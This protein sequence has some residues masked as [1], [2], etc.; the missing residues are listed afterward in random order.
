MKRKSFCLLILFII[1][2]TAFFCS[3]SGGNAE[4]SVEKSAS[5]SAKETPFD[6]I[7]ELTGPAKENIS[8]FLNGDIT[9]IKITDYCVDSGDPPEYVLSDGAKIKEFANLLSHESWSAEDDDVYT[10]EKF[11][12]TKFELKNKQDTVAVINL[13]TWMVDAY[14]VAEISGGSRTASFRISERAYFDLRAL[15]TGKYYLHKSDLKKPDKEISLKLQNKMLYGL[16]EDEKSVVCGDLRQAHYCLESLLLEN[17]SFL[18][19]PNGAGWDLAVTGFS[20]NVIR[21]NFSFGGVLKLLESICSNLKDRD[22][23]KAF[24]KMHNDLQSACDKRDLKGV[25]KVHEYIHDYDYFSVNYP[26][27]Y[28][29]AAAD[30]GGIDVYFGHLPRI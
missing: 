26:P 8:H 3:C 11:I 9:E 25:F 5:E 23:K 22:T 6:I 4:S 2:H 17:V 21:G 16:N 19:T 1:S 29:L 15:P 30:W 14:G 27:V 10:A 12:S 28:E 24:E 18:K 7:G 20:E 13:T